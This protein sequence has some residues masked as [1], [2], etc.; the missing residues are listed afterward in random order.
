MVV[1][2]ERPEHTPL[3]FRIDPVDCDDLDDALS[4]EVG[5]PCFMPYK[6]LKVNL[7]VLY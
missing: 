5:V 2:S 6:G 7:A 3:V 4:I 1:D